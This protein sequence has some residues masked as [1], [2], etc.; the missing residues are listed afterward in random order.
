MAKLIP[1]AVHSHWTTL[2]NNMVWGT[3]LGFSSIA[4]N[5]G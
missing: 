4:S 3:N 5:E 2:P 1:Q